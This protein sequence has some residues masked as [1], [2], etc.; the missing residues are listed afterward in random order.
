[1]GMPPTSRLRTTIETRCDMSIRNTRERKIRP[2]HPGEMLREDFLPDY[3]LTASG[4]AAGAA[5]GQSGHGASAV[6]SVRQYAGVLAQ[7]ATRGGPMGCGPG[8]QD[9]GEAHQAVEGRITT[10]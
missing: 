1:M 2:A 3:G 5:G 8:H 9:G 7:R 4:L 6:A 10:A